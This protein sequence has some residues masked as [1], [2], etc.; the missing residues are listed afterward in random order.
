M[1]IRSPE[2]ASRHVEGEEPNRIS[3]RNEIASL[4]GIDV[5]RAYMLLL[6]AN[7]KMG[8]SERE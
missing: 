2:R 6:H 5:I 4:D 1:H 3:C 8:M 7:N